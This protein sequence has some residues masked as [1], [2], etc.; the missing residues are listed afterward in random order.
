MLLE[1]G[2]TISTKVKLLFIDFRYLVL[3]NSKCFELRSIERSD[4]FM[5]LNNFAT[6][7]VL[8]AGG[9][10]CRFGRSARDFPPGLRC[11]TLAHAVFQ[12]IEQVE[13]IRIWSTATILFVV[14]EIRW[15]IVKVFACRHQFLFPYHSIC[16]I[17]MGGDYVWIQ[18]VWSQRVENAMIALDISWCS[19]ERPW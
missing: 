18:Y 17:S 3:E 10:D 8:T 2:S 14:V 12:R 7:V 9:S 5:V 19:N 13:Y 1:Y 11:M 4:R 16:S 15:M 6:N